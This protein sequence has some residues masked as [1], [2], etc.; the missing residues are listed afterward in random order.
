MRQYP[1]P[2]K[3]DSPAGFL[4]AMALLL[5]VGIGIWVGVAWGLS[6]I[7]HALG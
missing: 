2:F 1:E 5:P 6:S 4:R 3:D 7:F